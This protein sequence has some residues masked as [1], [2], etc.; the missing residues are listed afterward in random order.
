MD[1]HAEA[2]LSAL[3]ES[4][5]VLI[6]SVDLDCRLV[7][8][9][10]AMR[11]NILNFY[12]IDPKQG[13]RPEDLLPAEKA[14][15]WPPMYARTLAEGPFRAEYPLLDG[16]TLELAFNRIAID[17]EI[18]GVSVFGRD[19]TDR[20]RTQEALR[21][22]LDSLKEA[23]IN[24]AL[25]S[26]VLDVPMEVWTS[27]DVLD[28]IFGIDKEYDHTVAGW[29]SLIHPDDR[30]MI[31]SYFAG[32]V[33]GRGRA[34]DK[35]YRIVRQTD[36]AVRWVHGMG[37]LAFDAGGKPLKMRGM[38]Q[39]ITERR[40]SE[41]H[42]RESDERYRTAFATSLDGIAI[43]RFSDGRYLDVNRSFLDL[44]GFDRE[45]VI[46]R[47]SIELGSWTDTNIRLE[48]AERLR[49]NS[50]C[51]DL[52]I[53]YKR[54]N[55]EVFWMQLS[56]SVIE[57]EG[58]S[59]I[60]S[61]VRDISAAKVAE[62]R[63]V[64]ATEAMRASEERYR[65]AFQTSLDAININRL[66][67]G[68]FI[69]CNQ[70]FLDLSGYAREEVIGKTSKELDVWA[71]HRDRE[72]LFE[73][74]REDSSCRDF[75]AQFIR[76]NGEVRLGL[77]S[78]STM[79]VDG[80][81]CILCM[82]RD[83]SESKAA[84]DKIRNLAYY[85][86]LTG[87]PNRRL[88]MERLRK[89]LSSIPRNPRKQALL[90]IGI[91]NFKA[92]NESL[93]HQVGDLLLQEAAR[94][95]NSCLGEDGPA[96]RLSGDEFLVILEDLDDNVG[97]ASARALETAEKILAAISQPYMLGGRAI[98][99]TA[100][101][102]ITFFGDRPNT[103]NDVLQ[104]ADIALD[105]AQT[106]G[107]N[108]V[109][110]FA[111]ALQVA[112]NA[113]V[114]L[115]DELLLAIKNNQFVLHYQPQ[116]NRGR[117]IGAEALIRWNHPTRGLLAPGEFI[118]LAEETG[119]ILPLGAWVLET[120]CKQIAAWSDRL[121][122]TEFTLA[123]NISA[124]Q[125]RHP[126]FVQQVLS[127]I[128]RTG[129]NP[130]NIELELTESMLVENIEDVVAKMTVLKAHG[131]R[132]SLDDFGTGYSSLAYLKRLP[133]D[134]LKIDRSFVLDILLDTGSGAIAQTILSLSKA[135]GLPTIAEGVETEEQRA[136]LAGLGCHSF[137]GFLFSRPLPLEEFEQLWLGAV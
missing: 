7:S 89:T 28:A 119:L 47:S 123:V 5:D 46:G 137:Q 88:L 60:L 117:T 65:T 27:S 63:L 106:A 13:M 94:R 107:R 108:T 86:P 24:G 56:A 68:M 62:E 99:S 20:K 48:V 132:F 92:L 82:T 101:I 22:S 98:R 33:V 38:I 23:E 133:L 134:Q 125:F 29:R 102:G 83:T 14:A 52:T 32:E 116:V 85:D 49:R 121:T 11:L 45:E 35:E 118:P 25:G 81:P 2:N 53:P 129:A 10:Q 69:D 126:E 122:A 67:D 12:G 75:E 31:S 1:S 30:A 3:I 37:K 19:V 6:W 93:G 71:D 74:L 95:L 43:S 131:V 59:C 21:E 9:N 51:R 79:E 72:R 103:V 115:E 40:L 15:L 4:T 18:T 70:A 105:Q 90:L 57:I 91:D 34:F 136:F 128:E 39:D 77:M 8:F 97:E 55:G 120:A 42:L 66:Y 16:R 78:A 127:I 130:R 80:V 111:P 112:V 76:K 44:L 64:A 73:L 61:V 41:M 114:T 104:Q 110:F 135:M 58:V 87:L 109:R 100:S 113:R 17:G 26:Y 84:E 36:Q 96:A 50:V 124:R 54:K